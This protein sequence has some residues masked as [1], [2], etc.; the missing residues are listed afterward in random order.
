MQQGR[1][2]QRQPQGCNPSHGHCQP[3]GRKSAAKAPRRSERSQCH[4]APAL[5][6]GIESTG[7]RRRTLPGH[8]QGQGDNPAGG[9]HP[10]GWIEIRS[11]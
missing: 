4:P 10:Q 7:S 5:Q 11:A 1:G 8:P 3:Q 2:S 6:D 9:R